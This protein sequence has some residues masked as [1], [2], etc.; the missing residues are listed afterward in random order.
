LFS[1]ITHQNPVD[2]A[3]IFSMLR[4]HTNRTGR[5]FFTCFL[6][7]SIPTFED[8]SPDRNG[9]RCFYN[10]GFLVTLAE[11]CG[12]RF[13]SRMPGEGPLIGDSFVFRGT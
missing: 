3:C 1:V 12:W 10:P 13:V 11:G 8:R 4:R 9:G 5:L 2:S 7:D 6:D